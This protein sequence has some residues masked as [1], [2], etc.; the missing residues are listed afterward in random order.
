M[1]DIVKAIKRLI[2]ALR[3][4]AKTPTCCHVYGFNCNQGRDCPARRGK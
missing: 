2:V 1:S 3:N 4:L